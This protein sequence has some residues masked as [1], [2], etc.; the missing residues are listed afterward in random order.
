MKNKGRRQKA[1][2]TSDN[3]QRMIHLKRPHN[4]KWIKDVKLVV[5]NGKTY[6]FDSHAACLGTFNHNIVKVWFI[7]TLSNRQLFIIN[8]D[9]F[10]YKIMVLPC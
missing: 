7:K 5:S 1:G 2:R 4:N 10:I 6:I 8:Q 3:F 9:G